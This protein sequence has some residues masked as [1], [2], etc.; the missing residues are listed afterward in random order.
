MVKPV[1]INSLNYVQGSRNQFIYNFPSEMTFKTGD[2]I[3][4]QSLSIFNSTFNISQ[5]FGNNTFSMSFPI[6]NSSNQLFYQTL[7][8]TIP[9]G[10][11]T[12]SDLNYFLQS[13]MI[14]NNLYLV[15]STSQENVYFL[16]FTTNSVQYVLQINS[17][18]IYT[19]SQATALGLTLPNGASWKLPS[20]SYCPQI[21]LCQGL[22]TYFGMTTL[23][24]PPVSNYSQIFNQTSQTVPIVSTVNSYLI[25]LNIVNSKYSIPNNILYSLALPT[26]SY[27]TQLSVNN[28]LSDNAM[29]DINAGKYTQLVI[30]FLDQNFNKLYLNDYEI[31][32]ILNIATS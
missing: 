14:A 27:A 7:N 8:V 16:E 11:Y 6:A 12:V 4:L 19:Q 9:D 13:Q 20:V 2:K 22:G 25:T 31:V 28:N 26:S 1:V 32:L 3:G 24:L 30:T 10:Y 18:P 29:I 21:T 17:Y 15:N 23:T 5:V